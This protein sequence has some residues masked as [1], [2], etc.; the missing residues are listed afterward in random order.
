MPSG[1]F[2]PLVPYALS[3]LSCGTLYHLRIRSYA[4]AAASSKGG[5][6]FGASARPFAAGG[7]VQRLVCHEKVARVGMAF[8]R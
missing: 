7:C 3:N 4:A 8:A 6:A 5:Q 2:M 1:R